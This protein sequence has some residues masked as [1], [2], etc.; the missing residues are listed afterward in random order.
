MSD[1]TP[2]AEAVRQFAPT[3]LLGLSTVPGVFSEDVVRAAA[4]ACARPIVMPMS[5]PTSKSECTPEQAYTCARAAAESAPP[6]ARAAPRALPQ[7]SL[8]H[9]L[10]PL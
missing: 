1:G 9:L 5:N 3:C 4:D 2:M 6:S 8:S 10:L 7:G